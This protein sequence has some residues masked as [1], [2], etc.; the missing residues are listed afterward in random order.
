MYDPNDYNGVNEERDYYERQ[1]RLAE[2][3]EEQRE[4]ELRAEA[5]ECAANDALEL[6]RAIAPDAVPYCADAERD[7]Q[8]ERE[9]IIFTPRDLNT[10]FDDWRSAVTPRGIAAIG[11]G[12][13]VRVGSG[14]KTRRAA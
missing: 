7:E 1:E 9:A 6:A 11:N 10:V 12:L 3:R 4:A 2:A 5:L 14:R 13:F 8:S